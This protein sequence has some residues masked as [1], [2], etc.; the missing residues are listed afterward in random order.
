MIPFP[1][2]INAMMHSI[3]DHVQLRD[4]STDYTPEDSEMIKTVLKELW[5][6]TK[7]CSAKGETRH[8]YTL[9]PHSVIFDQKALRP[10]LLFEPLYLDALGL[11]RKPMSVENK[12]V[13]AATPKGFDYFQSTLEVRDEEDPLNMR[14]K[15]TDPLYHLYA[16]KTP[17]YA[18]KH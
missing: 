15:L 16:M 14:V 7:I 17:E 1:S 12:I 2:N 5:S 3:S 18:D 6:Y 13:F 11:S 4:A 10:S 8:Y 9:S